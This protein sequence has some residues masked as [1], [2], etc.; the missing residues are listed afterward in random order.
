MSRGVQLFPEQ[1]N[2]WGSLGVF[3]F[4]S[5]RSA[6]GYIKAKRTL[7]GAIQKQH[8]EIVALSGVQIKVET[9]KNQ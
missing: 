8:S 9:N 1:I 6:I 4:F 7:L 2:F 3:L 5:V